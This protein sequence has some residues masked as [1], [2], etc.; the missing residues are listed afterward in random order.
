MGA[1][2]PPASGCRPTGGGRARDFRP[3]SWREADIERAAGLLPLPSPTARTERAPA[4]AGERLTST[5][6][7]RVRRDAGELPSIAPEAVA[8]C[9]WTSIG[10][11]DQPS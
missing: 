1:S 10:R 9:A 11:F 4:R 6:Q 7:S 8:G 3:A 5:R 2:G